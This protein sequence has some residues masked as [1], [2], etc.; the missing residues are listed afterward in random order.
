[1][2]ASF[3]GHL[4]L[5]KWFVTVS[6][7]DILSKKSASGRTLI[8]LACN[9]GHLRVAQWLFEMGAD[10]RT[11]DISES[12]AMLFACEEG[13]CQVAQWL[14]EMGAA[15]DIRIKNNHGESPISSAVNFKF[16]TDAAFES[17]DTILTLARTPRRHQRR[18]KRPRRRRRLRTC[19]RG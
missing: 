4:E 17:H 3:N 16:Y 13:H 5:L 15:E 7:V 6:S 10:I 14:F 1:M 11:K 18:D 12:T 9:Q 19:P 2:A 8:M